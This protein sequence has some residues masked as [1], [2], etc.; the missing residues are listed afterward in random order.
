MQYHFH[1]PSAVLNGAALF[2]LSAPVWNSFNTTEAIGT[3]IIAL[4]I[5]MLDEIRHPH[6][7][8][9]PLDD[10]DMGEDD[11]LDPQH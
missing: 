4:I 5:W 9:I 10:I 1:V 11:D 6:P 2:A 3:T 8:F 7:V